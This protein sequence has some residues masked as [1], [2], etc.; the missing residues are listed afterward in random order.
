MTAEGSDYWGD[1]WGEASRCLPVE[2]PEEWQG[3][4]LLSEGP[5]FPDDD[6]GI[7]TWGRPDPWGGPW[8]SHEA[9]GMRTYDDEP[10]QWTLCSQCGSFG[11]EFRGYAERLSCGCLDDREHSKV[12]GG[13]DKRLLAAYPAAQLE[14]WHAD[15]FTAAHAIVLLPTR[16][17]GP[18]PAVRRRGR[19]R[20]LRRRVPVARRAAAPGAVSA[21]GWGQRRPGDTVFGVPVVRVRAVRR[22][23]GAR[24][25]CRGRGGGGRRWW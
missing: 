15:D 16:A 24:T 18:G 22:A 10:Y 6:P 11:A 5:F 17:R 21:G 13:S 7:G 25:V 23:A 4:T 3:L 20:E 12:A 19:R 8:R 1:G 14:Q 9:K 2:V